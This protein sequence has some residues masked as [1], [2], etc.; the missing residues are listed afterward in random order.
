MKEGT[1]KRRAT[2]KRSLAY[3]DDLTGIYNRRYLKKTKKEIEELQERSIPFS[4]VIVDIDHFKEINDTHGHLKGDE[5]IKEF[6]QFLTGTLRATDTVVRYGGDEFVCVMSNTESKDTQ[7][8]YAR[9]LDR[10]KKR[11]FGGLNISISAGIASYPADGGE[12][13]ELLKIADES[14]YDAKRSGRGRIGTIH[15]KRIELP[16]RVYVGRREEKEI[17]KG[18]LTEGNGYVRAAL[19]EGNIGIG[20]T[21]LV[22]EVLNTITGRE[23]LWSDC[24]AFFEGISY[25]PIR[26]IIKY[27]INRQGK[28]IINDIPFAY[29]IE[30]G[31]LIPEIMEEVKE[32]IDEIG[33][34][35]DKYRLY[36]SIRRIIELGE[37]K[38]III[39]DNMQWSDRETTEVIKYLLRSLRNS[40]ITFIFIYRQEEKTDVLEDFT[41]YISRETAVKKVG[42]EP[43]ERSGI[44]QMVNI[45]IGEKPDNELVT[46][47]EQGSGG[48]PFYVEEIIKGLNEAGY[49]HVEGDTWHFEGPGAK[50][51]PK[52]ID[53]IAERKYQGLSKEGREILEIAS[54]IGR[55]DIDIIKDITGYNE[56]HIIGV[57][58][59]IKRLGF[60]KEREDR[61]EFQEEISRGAIYKRYVSDM[62][63]RMLH[64]RIGEKIEEQYQGRE[65]EVTEELAFHFYRGM[66]RTKGVVYCLESGDRAREQYANQSAIR[67]YTW[68]EE[69]L[70]NQH[71][72][73]H[74]RTRIDCLLKRADVLSFIGDNEGAMKNFEE[75]L[76]LAQAI[77]DKKREVDIRFRKASLYVNISQ[78][79]KATEEANECIKLYEELSDKKGIALVLNAIG[80]TQGF[81]GEY[82][83]ALKNYEESLLIF[84]EIGDKNFEARVLNNQGLIYMNLGDHNK[85]LRHFED[86]LKTKAERGDKY[87]EGAA[88]NNI[89]LIYMSFGN[90]KEALKIYEDALNI[91][92][93]IGNKYGEALVL[94]NIG[95]IN[96][97]W[98]NYSEGLKFSEDALKIANDTENRYCEALA[99][100]NI[101][102]IHMHLGNYDRSLRYFDDSHK[103]AERTKSNELT[104]INLASLAY[105]YLSMGKYTEAKEYIDKV[106]NQAKSLKSQRM[107][108]DALAFLCDFY[109][110]QKEIEK[111]EETIQKLNEIP[112]TLR[113]KKFEGDSN[114]FMARYF[115]EIEDFTKAD[116]HAKKA[117]AIYDDMGD[118]LSTGIVYYYM[119]ISEL[120]KG[121]KT[122][123]KK[124]MK[125]AVKV[126]TTLGAKG[127][128][129]KADKMLK[130]NG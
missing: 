75:G 22:K 102:T 79:S 97:D 95:I 44:Q 59:T 108:R 120:Q 25:Y 42:L 50:I 61:I 82:N 123:Y 130:K 20:K 9:I 107:L 70:R 41:S 81:F 106:Y 58:E 33:L 27:K 11:N 113:P 78:Y 98:G 35:L 115:V 28:K 105:L 8:I 111:F 10:C 80:N 83:N 90:Y 77:A 62:K 66:D 68:A 63:G 103:I 12:F 71:D 3:L 67:Y 124:Q 43:L 30:I 13:D 110:G 65:H 2:K 96:G 6:S 114:L 51:I 46:Y 57:I 36:E 93:E 31:K 14:L 53:D 19:I 91:F 39:I 7:Q 24:L 47:I 60:I 26:E 109:L 87:R 15:K 69:L 5:V 52:S 85:A 1:K 126:F 127:W 94:N 34:V 119:G 122:A 99:L 48:N 125:K 38:K 72:I 32:R 129:V 54:V 88:L 40:P 104:F 128:K 18:F 17:L 16:T 74:K 92:R 64:K 112:E 100:K 76:K 37:T 73:E 84:R 121:D 117:L 23:I 56:G 21:R 86:S 29:K 116:K 4:V 55:F 89:G 118:R 45:I 49:L 101:G